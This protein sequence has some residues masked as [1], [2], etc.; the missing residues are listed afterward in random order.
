MPTIKI[1]AEGKVITK[2]GRPSC[3]CCC[4]WFADV[5]V[6][7]FDPNI[8]ITLTLTSGKYKCKWISG[9]A[10]FR[11]LTSANPNRWI[12]ALYMIKDGNRRGIF[13]GGEAETEADAIKNAMALCRGTTTFNVTEAN[14]GDYRFYFFD[15]NYNDNNSVNLY[16]EIYKC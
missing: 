11:S 8:G 15:Q 12:V 7:S 3:A 16:F 2:C 1:T 9:V 10:R 5:T 13:V 4:P 6:N 14:A